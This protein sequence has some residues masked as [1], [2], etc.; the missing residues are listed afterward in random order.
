MQVSKHWFEPWR[1][2]VSLA[3][4]SSTN[5]L[6]VIFPQQWRST[7][8]CM[9][10]HSGLIFYEIYLSLNLLHSVHRLT[11]LYLYLFLYISKRYQ[12]YIFILGTFRFMPTPSFETIL[13]LLELWSP[14]HQGNRTYIVWSIGKLVRGINF[15]STL[16]NP[17]KIHLKLN[18][19]RWEIFV[20]GLG[21]G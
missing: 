11:Y 6:L 4:W 12:R 16:A 7:Y 15:W 20:I 19:Y 18:G 21:I 10:F 1:I 5:E 17:T 14:L 3:L 8:F 2:V 13:L 9:P